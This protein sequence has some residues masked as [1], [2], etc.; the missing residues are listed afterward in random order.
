MLVALRA[1]HHFGVRSISREKIGKRF[2]LGL[3]AKRHAR[4]LAGWFSMPEGR[5]KS[6]T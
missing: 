4:R 1:R 6:R 2:E 5:S 3:A